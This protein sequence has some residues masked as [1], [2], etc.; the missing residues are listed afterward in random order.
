MANNMRAIRT[1]IRSIENTRQI[2][3]SMRMVSAAKLRR[4]QLAWNSLREYDRVCRDILQRVCGAADPK[5]LPLLA[6]REVRRVCY[7]LIVGSRGL[8][9]GYNQLLL[10]YAKSVLEADP[11]GKEL[12]VVGRWGREHLSE[13]N[14]EILRC[15]DEFSD[16]PNPQQGRELADYLLQR[17][18]DG[19]CDEIVLVYQRFVSVLTQEPTMR[20]LL[21][22]QPKENMAPARDVI[23]EPDAETLLQK[24]SDLVLHNAVYAALLEAQTGEHA[25]RMT[26]MSAAT[27]NTEEL[28]TK[29]S[30]EL[31]HARQS[32]IT[33]EI[34]EIVGGA[35]ALEKK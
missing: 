33:T 19:A 18:L 6:E 4:S 1:R 32:A 16:T 24:L 20:K 34:S 28:I 25:A 23:F 15:F 5:K 22:M 21:P 9:G 10:R 2:T 26:A 29:L 17:Y 14:Q 30:L 12:V 11:R 31:N 27:D 8:C 7:V 13:L 3:L 35:N